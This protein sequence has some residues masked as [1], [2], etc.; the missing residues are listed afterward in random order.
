MSVADGYLLTAGLAILAYGCFMKPPGLK[1]KA[2]NVWRVGDFAWLGLFLML[3]QVPV[4]G[5]QLFA[6]ESYGPN[7]SWLGYTGALLAAS[8]MGVT[9]GRWTEWGK[10][11]GRPAT[12]IDSGGRTDNPGQI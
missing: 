3:I 2:N 8:G 7:V 9:I 6:S 5:Y 1:W 4:I 12:E 11:S 10:K